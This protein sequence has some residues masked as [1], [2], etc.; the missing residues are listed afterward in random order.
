MGNRALVIFRNAKEISPVV[1]LHWNGDDVLDYLE[2]YKKC[3][4]NRKGD[5]DYICARFIGICHTEING[6]LSLGVWNCAA[7]W[8]E[9]IL[10]NDYETIKTYSHGDNSI[11]IVDVSKE[12]WF[13]II[14]IGENNE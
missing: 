1:Y 7:E 12:N 11:F 5:V 9:S 13:N 10:N 8:E 2:D 3:M 4:D 6:N 14:Q